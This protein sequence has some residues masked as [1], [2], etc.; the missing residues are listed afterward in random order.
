MKVVTVPIM[1][2]KPVVVEVPETIHELAEYL[3]D[4]DCHLCH[5]E[6]CGWYYENSNKD[7]WEYGDH[8]YWLDIAKDV[9]EN[10]EKDEE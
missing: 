1:N 7:K 5:V 4:R 6:H 9:M 10:G 2:A 3:H 8:K